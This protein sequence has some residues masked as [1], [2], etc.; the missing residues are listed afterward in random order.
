MS[1]Y[2]A[3][4]LRA[5]NAQVRFPALCKILNALVTAYLFVQGCN[6]ELHPVTNTAKLDWLNLLSSLSAS[7]FAMFQLM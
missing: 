2:K 6:D 3:H 5:G 4:E 1:S 7:E